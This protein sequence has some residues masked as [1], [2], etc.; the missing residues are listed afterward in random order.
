MSTLNK[1]TLLGK[2]EGAVESK[3]TSDGTPFVKFSISVPRIQA[4][5]LAA[6]SDIIPIVAW[7]QTA[8]AAGREAV[9]GA[10]VVVEGRIS[11]RTYDDDQGKRHYVTE[12]EARDVVGMSDFLGISAGGL[13]PSTGSYDLGSSDEF[14]SQ[15]SNLTEK[16]APGLSATDFDFDAGF[17]KSEIPVPPKFDAELEDSIPF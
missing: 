9:T 5:G 13:A 14:K 3:V 12:V 8:E 11:T 17:M 7:R 1:I 15:F 10:V 16:S 4:G 2:V 6:A